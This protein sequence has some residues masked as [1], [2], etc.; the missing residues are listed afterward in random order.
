MRVHRTGYH[1]K[2]GIECELAWS[3][4]LRKT[5]KI[6]TPAPIP[7]FDG[8]LVQSGRSLGKQRFMVMFEHVDGRHPRET[9][10]LV[11]LF[12]VLGTMAAQLHDHASGWST[13]C[14]FERLTWDLETVFGEQ[15]T[16]GHWRHAPGV[17]PAISDL[18]ARA[19]QTIIDRLEAFGEG[20][21]RFG[22]IH[23]DMR[24]ANLLIEGK[25]TWLI[26]FDDCGLGWFL[27]DFASGVSFMEDHP[28]LP[29][30]KSAWTRGYRKVRL[31]SR[32][33]EGEIGS[34]VMFRRL[35]LL[36]WIGS[37]IDA[38]EPRMLAPTFAKVTAELAETYLTAYGR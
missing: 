12:E 33:E 8:E 11:G 25:R 3:T 6:L 37:H 10:D 26:D 15:P 34:F 5:G 22:L 19:E 21:D 28:R 13:P 36:A 7:G 2:A 27:Y 17:T 20:A 30:L 23:A 38:P 31:L 14:P 18:L 16:W 9:D 29:E 35:A 32:E 4:A 1:T 24:L